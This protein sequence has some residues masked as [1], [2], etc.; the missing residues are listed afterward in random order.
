MSKPCFFVLRQRRLNR[1]WGRFGRYLYLSTMKKATLLQLLAFSAYFLTGRGV[2]HTHTHTHTF[3][4]NFRLSTTFWRGPSG[5]N[6][7]FSNF[8][9]FLFFWRGRGVKNTQL[10]E[11]L[12]FPPLSDEGRVKKKNNVFCNFWPFL[13][14]WR[15]RGVKNA[16]IFA[17]FGLFR[18]FFDGKGSENNSRFLKILVFPPLSVEGREKKPTF[19]QL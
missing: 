10:F 19:L 15:G 7:V 8:W 1:S 18:L 2:K 6:N 11:I 14:F 13:L 9:P 5:K 12:V 17:T 4:E 16:L 3:V